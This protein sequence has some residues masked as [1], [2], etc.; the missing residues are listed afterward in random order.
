MK[1]E[2]EEE[3]ELIRQKHLEKLNA[4]MDKDFEVLSN[5]ELAFLKAVSLSSI[6]TMKKAGY[7]ND[8]IMLHD[9]QNKAKATKTTIMKHMNAMSDEELEALGFKRL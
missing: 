4:I 3:K 5:N 7:S 1:Y 6:M 9:Q 8:E 2:T